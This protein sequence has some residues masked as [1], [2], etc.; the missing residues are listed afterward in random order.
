MSP[1]FVTWGRTV[2]RARNLYATGLA[3]AAFFAAAGVMLVFGLEAA[4]GS[5]AA[6]A[7]LWTTAVAAVLPAFAAIFAMDA[8]S[9]ERASGRMELL[10]ATGV[11]ERDLTLGKFLGVWTLLALAVVAFLLCSL[12]TLRLL[13]PMLLAGVRLVSFLPGVMALFLQGVLWTAVSVFTSA[14]FA[15][16][17]T[18]AAFSIVLTTAVPHA[19]WAAFLAWASRGR[20]A[21]GEMP[22]MAHAFD[23]ASGVVSTGVLAFY[24]LFAVTAL[25]AATKTIEALRF[26]G[27]RSVLRCVASRFA[28]FLSLVVAVLF[29]ILAWRLDTTLDIPVEGGEL[30]FSPRT[31]HILSDARGSLTVTAFLSRKDPRFRTVSHFLRSLRREAEMGVG[32]SLRLAYVDPRWDVGAAARFVRLGVP[33]GSVVFESGR[34]RVAIP[35]DES[36][37]ERVT[38]SAILR[39]TM[40]PQ[41]RV[42]CWTT[43][44]GEFDFDDYGPFGLSDMARE[45]ARDGYRNEHLDLAAPSGVPADCALVVVAGAKDGFARAELDRIGAYLKSGGRMLVLANGVTGGVASLLPEWGVRPLAASAMTAR[46]LTGTDVVTSEFSDHVISAPLQGSQVVLGRPIL[47]APSA[48]ADLGGG[49]DQIDFSPLVRAGEAVLAAVVERGA[50]AGSDTILRPTRIAVVGDA[51]FVLNAG[52]ETGANANRDFFLNCAAYLSGTDALTSG[53]ADADMLSS[54]M[55]RGQR[56]VFALVLTIALPLALLLVFSAMVAGRR[57]AR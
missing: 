22:L 5:R 7:P 44:H 27:A 20:T 40:P 2:S 1:V 26:S 33:A 29:V 50:R 14:L 46:T 49:A 28:G 21:F 4:E 52:L 30:R 8:W 32:V 39:L 17:A 47:L 53:G 15:R 11:S 12:L 34:H 31:R 36:F 55:D 18:A 25:F 56:R 35:L 16:P 45:L 3:L 9:D 51:S 19:A 6:L 43:G 57:R 10:L 42:V 41:R 54:G 38:A 37:G 13:A 23:M 24:L 48:A